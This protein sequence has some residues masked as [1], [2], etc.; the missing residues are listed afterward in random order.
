[1]PKPR[2]YLKVSSFNLDLWLLECFRGLFHCCFACLRYIVSFASAEVSC[3]L[4]L[5]RGDAPNN[6][7]HGREASGLFLN[8]RCS[9]HCSALSA[10]LTAPTNLFFPIH[11]S[12]HPV[13]YYS[14]GNHT[15]PPPS[16]TTNNTLIFA[17]YSHKHDPDRM[18]SIC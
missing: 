3:R 9:A 10:R 6:L 5:L 15:D 2:R 16:N 17:F 18:S 7:K 1:M 8:A 14:L 11:P 4:Q 12:I 13:D